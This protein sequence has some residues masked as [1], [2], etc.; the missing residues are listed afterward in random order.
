LTRCTQMPGGMMPTGPGLLLA[1]PGVATV[2]VT[3]D[4]V[5][6]TLMV[7]LPKGNLKALCVHIV[8]DT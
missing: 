4:L 1:A 7:D 5:G 2:A 8:A 3:T 6:R